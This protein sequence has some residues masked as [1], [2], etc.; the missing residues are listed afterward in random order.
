MGIPTVSSVMPRLA[1]SA[2]CPSA[3]PPPWLPMA[4]M[5]N[6]RAPRSRRNPPMDARIAGRLAIRRL[7]AVMPIRLPVR[8]GQRSADRERRTSSPGSGEWALEN[9]WRT[10][11][12]LGSALLRSFWT[13]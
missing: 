11:Y 8:S 1:S 4:G 3:V 12:I 2:V 6:G 5:M 13:A 10:R 9:C 7:P